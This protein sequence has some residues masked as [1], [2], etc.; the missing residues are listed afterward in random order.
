MD[1]LSAFSIT[2]DVVTFVDFGAKLI[3]LYRE[4]GKSE[5]G[6]PAATSALEI[7]SQQITGNASYAR[8]KIANLQ[9]RYPQQSE[10][11]TRLVAECEQAEKEMRKLVGNPTS[12]GNALDKARVAFRAMRKKGDVEG[13]Q[14]RLK[15]IHE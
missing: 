12:H 1:P 6:R 7:E 9:T 8:G 2:T 10:Q 3:S 4:I 14:Q 5:D 13:L 15:S 11:L